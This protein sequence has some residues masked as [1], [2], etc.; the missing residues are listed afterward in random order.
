MGA[1]VGTQTYWKCDGAGCQASSPSQFSQTHASSCAEHLGWR[2]DYSNG[3][4][5][6]P[7]CVKAM[8]NPK[9]RINLELQPKDTSIYSVVQFRSVVEV[10]G[11]G[12]DIAYESCLPGDERNP[13]VYGL[14]GKN[15]EGHYEWITDYLDYHQGLAAAM[16]YAGFSDKA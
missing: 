13:S 4:T 12:G 9:P 15:S 8:D 10:K 1:I 16:K 2:K 14:Y 3:K 7:Q 6:C 11:E 5:Y